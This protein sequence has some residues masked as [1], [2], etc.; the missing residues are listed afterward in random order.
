MNLQ[1]LTEAGAIIP[2]DLKPMPITWNGNTFNV[3]VRRLAY[4][5]AEHVYLSEGSKN[6]ALVSACVRFGDG[7]E[8]AT[9]AQVEAF[10][11]QLVL[12]LL[13]A[14]NQANGAAFVEADAGN[15]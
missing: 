4:A 15:V 1:Q 3:H 10:D 9:V 12:T 2:R 11:P 14:V 6:A 8:Q 13:D 7:T 5:E